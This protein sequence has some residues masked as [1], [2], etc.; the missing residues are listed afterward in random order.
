MYPADDITVRNNTSVCHYFAL[1]WADAGYDVRVIH[2]YN[3]YPVIFYPF[4]KLLNNRLASKTG[5]GIPTT[6]QTSAKTYHIDN[7]K[8]TRIPVLKLY[9]HGESLPHSIKKTVTLI[10]N[11]LQ[12]EDYTPDYILGHFLHPTIEIVSKLKKIYPQCITTVSLHG[13][14]NKYKPKLAQ[15][16]SSIDMVGYRS[17]PIRHSI[18]NTYGTFPCFMSFSGVPASYISIPK[19]FD[20]GIHRFLYAGSLIE[21]K[22]PTAL[23]PAIQKAMSD[24]DYLITFIGEGG[25]EGKIRRISQNIGID[26]HVNI[27]HRVPRDIVITEMDKSD[28]F[29]MISRNETFGLVYLEAMSRGCVVIASKNEGME[30]IIIH[31]KN[32]F[33][34]PAGDSKEL[35]NIIRHI[36]SLSPAE[37]NIIST[38]AIK[39]AQEMTDQKVA[40]NYIK[41]VENKA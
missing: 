8:I 24:N 25:E 30:G 1:Q 20:N 12:E 6:R 2:L 23:L 31:G 39:T 11:F 3:T 33:L 15:L 16:L 7:I 32:G 13:Q 41:A 10:D 22:H 29:I 17:Y 36:K 40:T 34:C 4:I 9:P 14:E 19:T 5:I 37:L 18:E 26:D 38:N 27:T 35:E 28:V 21:R